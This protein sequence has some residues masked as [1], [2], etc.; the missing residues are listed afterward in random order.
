MVY[1]FSAMRGR[2][3][4]RKNV[5]K[6]HGSNDSNADSA[7]ANCGYYL[8][9]EHRLIRRHE[10]SVTLGVDNEATWQLKID[11]ELPGTEE[12]CWEV[13]G[14][15]V[16]LFPLAYLKKNEAR[17]RFGVHEAD[18]SEVQLQ[19]R[20]ECDWISATAL[21]QAV[22][23]LAAQMEEPRPQFEEGALR[24]LLMKIPGSNAYDAAVALQ[25]LRQRFG[26]A[27]EGDS[28]PEDLQ[29]RLASQLIR[30][31]VDEALENLVEHSL[32]WVSLRG[33]FNEKRSISLRQEI[34]LERRAPIRWSFGELNG[35]WK[36]L[37][38]RRH[39]DSILM[40]GG[41]P[42][43]RRDWR[44]SFSALGERIGQPLAWM[45]FEF[46]LP[47]IYARRCGSY[48][49]E[50]RCPA[51]RTPR[52]LKVAQ[53]PVLSE[54]AN[55]ESTPKRVE[56]TRKTLTSRSVR[57]DV[58]RGGLKDV[59]RFRVI[60]GIGDGAF[61]VL[62]FLVGAITAAMLWALADANPALGGS[63][64]QTTAGILLVVPALVAALAAGS[65][66]VPIS[67]L[68][69]GARLLLLASG[70]SA[71]V[72]ATVLAGARPFG[73]DRLWIWS[74]CAV[75]A[76]AATVPLATSWLLSSPLVWRGLMR[77]S[78]YELQ[79]A[80]LA[81]GVAIALAIIAGLAA[82]GGDPWP[83]V[84]LCGV[85]LILMIVLAAL[86]NNRAAM[87]MGESRRYLGLAFLFAGLTC[88]ALACV[89]LRCVVFEHVLNSRNICTGPER[90]QAGLRRWAEW[91][92]TAALA[93]SYALG[94]LI[95]VV[96]ARADPRPDE[97]HV[98][99]RRGRALLRKESVRELPELLKR[100]QEA[101]PKP[102]SEAT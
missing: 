28:A 19:T 74:A 50:V 102:A 71:V 42:Y 57:F 40:I 6:V 72:A 98:S 65:N 53:G 15:R 101:F 43:G 85:L 66:E 78:F 96:S 24:D 58:P 26:L 12:A 2:C 75:A 99:P 77:L 54:S 52:D 87:P 90:S 25:E 16:F 20:E 3:K 93:L 81:I 7:S 29:K 44:F 67:Q 76:T 55:R 8:R 1:K 92:A 46:D 100:E 38:G 34:T 70:L 5:G 91:S 49:F 59:A 82:L 94:D 35:P 23:S 56:G 18:G 30:S 80:A 86:A 62:W 88:L 69:G 47:T 22:C 41:K 11:F 48:H 32:V 14:G 95:S 61:P 83:R 37:A 21:A 31:G 64:A 45:P 4:E 13:D 33:R 17:I 68:V 60:V 36:S 10:E 89:E 27:D 63:A 51:G 84:G 79:K 9:H 97:V 39:D 73:L